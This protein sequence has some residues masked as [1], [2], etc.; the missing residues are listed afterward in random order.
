MLFEVRAT[1]WINIEYRRQRWLGDSKEAHQG[2]INLIIRVLLDHLS[3]LSRQT[4]ALLCVLKFGGKSIGFGG[5]VQ[6][7]IVIIYIKWSLKEARRQGR[8]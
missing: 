8:W 3:L 6:P 1:A 2:C 5:K 7:A 4:L